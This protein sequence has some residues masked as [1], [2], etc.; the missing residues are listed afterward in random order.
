MG[1][2]THAN[3]DDTFVMLPNGMTVA[4]EKRITVALN[5][6]RDFHGP[7]V[8]KAPNGDLLLSHKDSE[9]HVGGD[10]FVRQ[11]R[12]TDDGFTWIDEGIVADWRSECLD[13]LFGEY[14]VAPDGRMAMVVQ[15]VRP[16]VG[17]EGCTSSVWYVSVDNGASWEFQGLVDP[18]NEYAVMSARSLTT[19]D[20]KIYFGTWSRLG[21]ALYSSEDNMRTWKRR[22]VIFPATHPGFD[23][24]SNAGPPFYPHVMFLPGGRL[25]AMTYCTPPTNHCYVRFSDD[26]GCTWGPIIERLDLPIWAPRMNRMGD[27]LWIV[28]GRDVEEHVTAAFF[29][30]DRG[31]SWGNKLVVDR[32]LFFPGSQGYSSSISIGP[33]RFWVFTSSVQHEGKGGIVGVLLKVNFE[34]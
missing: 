7:C 13:A 31:E 8:V 3:T 32:P 17:D 2:P 12:S 19:W 30:V 18:S 27:D 1:L 22:S 29:S 33:D 26:C 4:V 24:L 20:G 5:P 34:L 23:E 16:L 25:M 28:T 6:K 21:N 15:R 14:G 10:S 9:V 11:W